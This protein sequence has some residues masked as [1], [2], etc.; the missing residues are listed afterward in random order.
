MWISIQLPSDLAERLKSRCKCTGELYREVIVHATRAL[1]DP[2]RPALPAETNPP[3]SSSSP[4]PHPRPPRTPRPAARAT[5][6]PRRPETAGA[7]A[8]RARRAR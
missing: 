7:L 8:K 1:L 5:K 3:S 2:Q 6:T 4:P